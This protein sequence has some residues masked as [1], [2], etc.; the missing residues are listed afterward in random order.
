MILNVVR[1]YPDALSLLTKNST[2]HGEF[3]DVMPYNVALE[4]TIETDIDEVSTRAFKVS[5][6]QLG[7]GFS[8]G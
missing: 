4:A 7:S 1:A 5:P 2:C 6:P 8:A 3:I